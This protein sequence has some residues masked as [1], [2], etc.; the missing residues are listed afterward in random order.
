[1]AFCRAAAPRKAPLVPTYTGERFFKLCSRSADLSG[2][3]GSRNADECQKT[4]EETCSKVVAVLSDDVE[5]YGGYRYGFT[6]SPTLEIRFKH[7][8]VPFHKVKF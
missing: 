6:I 3:P 5:G 1:M 7:R 2:P 8:I 4:I